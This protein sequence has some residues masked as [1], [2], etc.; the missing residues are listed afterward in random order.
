MFFI[1][2]DPPIIYPQG[3]HD[4]SFLS[5]PLCRLENGNIWLLACT[6]QEYPGISENAH[7]HSLAIASL[8]NAG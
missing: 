3:L 6:T 4:A 8:L 2:Y 1:L 7:V 5:S